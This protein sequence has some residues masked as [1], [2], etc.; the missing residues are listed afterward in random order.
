[1]K[2][3][4]CGECGEEFSKNQLDAEAFAAGDYYCK[5]C[6]DFLAQA[7][8]DAVDPDH[9]FESYEDWDENGR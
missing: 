2:K 9:N 7:G 1:M 5:S 6:A 8:W 4:P 3:Y